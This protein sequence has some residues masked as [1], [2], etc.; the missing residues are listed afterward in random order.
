MSR[1]RQLQEAAAQLAV[2]TVWTMNDACR[3]EAGEHVGRLALKLAK[4]SGST[5][6]QSFVYE[7]LATLNLDHGNISRALTY[8]KH[9]VKLRE[10]P[11]AQEAWMRIRWGWALA[12]VRGQ[13]NT[14]RDEI[15]AI[16]G[17]LADRPDVFAGQG[18]TGSLL[19]NT[20]SASSQS[21]IMAAD[22]TG[23]IG[24]SLNDLGIYDEA[25]A[26]FDEC[27]RG[28]EQTSPALTAFFLSHQIRAALGASQF[29]LGADRM[30]QLARV[31]P[32]VNSPRV[33]RCLKNV[34]AQSARWTT[35]PSIRTAR[36]QLKAVA[37]AA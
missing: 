7:A 2:Q 24:L 18:V 14:A 4:A 25:Q 12:H 9:G 6:A 13:E 23:T 37:P 20:R 15:E 3:L 21:A 16:R 19:K 29:S 36:D 34:L 5:Q 10:V 11:D 35:V 33:D 17:L 31:A 1:D 32:L 28:M 27:V 30:H 22:M 26:A 8:A